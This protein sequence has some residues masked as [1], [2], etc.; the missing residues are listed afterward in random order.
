MPPRVIGLEPK[1]TVSLLTP[2]LH[3]QRPPQSVLIRVTSVCTPH[4]WH[5]ER[6][7][8]ELSLLLKKK[9]RN[10]NCRHPESLQ[11][12]AMWI[13]KQKLKSSSGHICQSNESFFFFFNI[14]PDKSHTVV[15]LRVWSFFPVTYLDPIS[16]DSQVLASLHNSTWCICWVVRTGTK[17][18][19]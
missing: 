7:C 6:T 13:R 9:K 3:L 16:C 2:L 5:H 10:A 8:V 17:F 15:K 4:P 18:N 12:L 19:L 14:N 11:N 1:K